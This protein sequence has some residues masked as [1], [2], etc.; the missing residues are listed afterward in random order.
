[1]ASSITAID[2]LEKRADPAQN[3]LAHTPNVSGE[4]MARIGCP[5][6][7]CRSVL[8][9]TG[10]IDAMAANIKAAHN[11]YI[12][13]LE[14]MLTKE[15]E[16]LERLEDDSSSARSHDE[17]AAYDTQWDIL[18]AKI[19]MLEDIIREASALMN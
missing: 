10:E 3:G 18:D 16:D 5:C 12:Q 17:M 4:F 8:D 15:R 19:I 11:R 14:C 2:I 1:M 6:C 9:P 7:T 13:E